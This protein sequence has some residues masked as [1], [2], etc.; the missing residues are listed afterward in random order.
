[1]AYFTELFSRA[2][3]DTCELV[4]EDPMQVVLPAF[5]FVIFVIWDW[6]KSRLDDVRKLVSDGIKTVL[7]TVLLFIALFLAHLLLLSP[8]NLVN[9]SREA[10]TAKD[11]DL[12]EEKKRNDQLQQKLA[13]TKVS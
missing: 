1:M 11:K 13:A 12:N 2:W 8:M 3:K 10:S 9:E 5:V 6:R 7:A 4:V